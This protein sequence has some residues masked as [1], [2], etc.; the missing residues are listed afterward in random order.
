VGI[1]KCCR[2]PVTR[3][4]ALNFNTLPIIVHS[5]IFARK[6]YLHLPVTGTRQP[7]TVL[8]GYNYRLVL[9]RVTAKITQTATFNITQHFI[10]RGKRVAD[11]G[12]TIFHGAPE[13][14]SGLIDITVLHDHRIA[15]IEK[16]IFLEIDAIIAINAPFYLQVVSNSIC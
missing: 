15:M 8:S 9:R 6:L 4:Q 5:A 3:Y 14:E 12:V 10:G 11:I 2:L 1:G 16:S 13:I 7:E